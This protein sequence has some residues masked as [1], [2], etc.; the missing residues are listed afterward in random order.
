MNALHRDLK[1]GEVVIVRQEIYTGAYDLRFRCQSG[2]GMKAFT[3]GRKIYGVFLEDGEECF[4]GGGDI[5][6]EATQEYQR[7]HPEQQPKEERY[8]GSTPSAAPEKPA[9]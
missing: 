9:V 4:I 3:E 5:H 6:V 8:D 7:R 1:P 2:F